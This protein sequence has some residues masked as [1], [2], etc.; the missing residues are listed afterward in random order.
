MNESIA[1]VKDL[2]DESEKT[3]LVENSKLHL[4]TRFKWYEYLV[5]YLPFAILLSGGAIGAGLGAGASCINVAIF[6]KMHDKPAKKYFA[7]L[8][9]TVLTI[10]I[11]Y[12]I[13]LVFK[14]K[15]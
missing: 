11:N 15:K 5:M 1:K 10:L 14:M 6:K 9:V 2:A 12:G 3:S 8:G 4:G 7:A 13:A